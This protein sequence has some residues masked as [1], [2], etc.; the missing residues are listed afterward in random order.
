MT[1]TPDERFP[2]KGFAI[3]IPIIIILGWALV[4]Y[5]K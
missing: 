2:W 1:S 4:F 5:K 3:V